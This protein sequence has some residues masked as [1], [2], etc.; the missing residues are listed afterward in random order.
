MLPTFRDG[1]SVPS[2]RVSSKSN[3]QSTLCHIP[4]ELRPHLYTARKPEFTHTIEI[5]ERA[6]RCIMTSR[7][8]SIVQPITLSRVSHVRLHNRRSVLGDIGWSTEWAG[9]LF[10]RRQKRMIPWESH[11]QERAQWDY[12]CML[13]QSGKQ[14]GMKYRWIKNCTEG[15]VETE[16]NTFPYSTF[17]WNLLTVMRSEYYWN[18]F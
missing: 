9:V 12:M 2:Y 4:R 8:V 5:E 18:G 1:L 14:A 17:S 7:Q 6:I 10:R 16:I 15:S 11:A 13:S 3:Y